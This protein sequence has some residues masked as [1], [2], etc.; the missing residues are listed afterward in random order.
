MPT[1]K[2]LRDKEIKLPFKK[3]KE[4]KYIIFRKR[5]SGTSGL[6]K[7]QQKK[8]PNGYIYFIKL[9]EQN[10][11]KIGVSQSVSRRLSDI[12]NSLPF[13]F[14]ILSLHYTEDVYSLEEYILNK[15]KDYQLKGE[16]FKLP[17]QKAKVIMTYLHLKELK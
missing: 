10:V 3:N 9:K 14:D 15:F 5:R 7:T 16:W 12:N 6:R 8:Y 13:D 17:T 2:G 1:K 11:Y 4:G